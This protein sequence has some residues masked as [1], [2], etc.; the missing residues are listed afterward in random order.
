MTTTF[1][2]SF[3]RLFL[4]AALLTGFASAATIL[5]LA[6]GQDGSGN[7]QTIGDSVD[8]NWIYND[9]FF[10]PAT[11]NA[12]VVGATSA[13]FSSSWFANGPNSSWIAPDPDTTDN[14]PAPYTFSLTFDTNGYYLSSLAFVGGGWAIDDQGTLSLNGNILSTL[15]FGSFFNLSPFSPPNED[16]V[17]GINTLTITI[18]GD[19]DFEEGVRL[20]GMLTGTPTPEPSTILLLGAGLIALVACSKLRSGSSTEM[21]LRSDNAGAVPRCPFK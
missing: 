17:N 1:H 19:D 15:N 8:A 14:G 21:P 7:I 5:N 11:G 20:E 10:S 6:T 9:S 4:V 3:L 2:H 16:F 18:T 13:D 12:K